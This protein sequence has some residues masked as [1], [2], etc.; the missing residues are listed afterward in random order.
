MSKHSKT[1][2]REVAAHACV[3]PATASR[4]LNG[5]TSVDAE[6]AQ[7]VFASA[8]ALGYHV[9]KS[10]ERKQSIA[11]ILPGISNTY[12]SHTATG[13]ID[14]AKRAGYLVNVMLSDSDPDQELDCLMK[15]CD[16]NT[17]G[18]I[19]APITNRDPRAASPTLAYM[20]IVVT[21][22]R[23]IADGLI[24]VHLDN[25]EAAYL[26][27]RYLLRLG[28][29][30]IAFFIHYWA[31][32]IQNYED[33]IKKYQSSNHG[34]FTRARPLRRVLPGP[35]GSRAGTESFFAGFRRLQLRIRLFRRKT[36]ARFRHRLRC[37]DRSERPM[38]R[39]HFEFPAGAG[40]QCPRSGVARMLRQ[41]FDCESHVSRLTSISS[42][43]Y[44]IGRHCAEQL[45][46]L[47]NGEPAH[48]VEIGAKLQIK[49]STQY[50]S[51]NP[52]DSPAVYPNQ[53]GPAIVNRTASASIY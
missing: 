35:G 14:A 37:G 3:S 4:A 1:N 32:H 42:V 46:H 26:C 48:D 45:F 13:V 22:P 30:N 41:R 10:T 51:Y 28:R 38:R 19:I 15:A 2:I 17:A 27:T 11:L 29:K 5:N 18:I 33:F 21:G 23:F 47:I 44:E 12:Y 8:R 6:L 36:A 53:V 9:N 20:P 52:A 50:I 31:E 34:C 39:G 7:R 16:P 43:D 40:F 49:N 25:N 24:H